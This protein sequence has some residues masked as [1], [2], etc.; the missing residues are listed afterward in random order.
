AEPRGD[1]E[2]RSM[3]SPQ[4]PEFHGSSGGGVSHSEG[5]R[6]GHPPAGNRVRFLVTLLIV[7]ILLG[8][9]FYWIAFGW[10]GTGGYWWHPQ[11]TPTQSSASR[12]ITGTGL[13]AMNATDRRPYIGQSFQLSNVPI[14]RKI[15]NQMFWIGTNSQS[16]I[17]VVL[18]SNQNPAQFNPLSTGNTVDVTGKVMKAPPTPDAASQW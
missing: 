9:F 17:L 12:P 13:A 6:P 3:A 5:Q 10:E 14:Q 16:P 8:A 2:V 18:N 4:R 1:G 11:A 7:V 15:K